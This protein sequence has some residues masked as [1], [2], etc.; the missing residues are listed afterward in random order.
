MTPEIHRLLDLATSPDATMPEAAAALSAVRRLGVRIH[1][2]PDGWVWRDDR[3]VPETPFLP[4]LPTRRPLSWLNPY[5]D[6]DEPEPEEKQPIVAAPE[7]PTPQTRNGYLARLQ[8]EKEERL[9]RMLELLRRPEGATV[10]ELV[11]VSG[12]TDVS[13]GVRLSRLRAE[14]HNVRMA[15]GRYVLA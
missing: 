10:E 8:G 6:L 13:V 14:G 5:A 2:A 3:L 11:R 4:P 7:R 9:A 15:H 1:D 12:Y